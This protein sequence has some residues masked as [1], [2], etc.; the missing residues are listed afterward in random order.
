MDYLT[1]TAALNRVRNSSPLILL[2][3]LFLDD[4]MSA[5]IPLVL[6]WFWIHALCH[7]NGYF[8]AT[9][10]IF[11]RVFL[12]LLVEEISSLWLSQ[13]KTQHTIHFLF[14]TQRALQLFFILTMQSVCERISGSCNMVRRMFRFRHNSTFAA[15]VNWVSVQA[16]CTNIFSRIA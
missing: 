15:N 13:Y 14:L 1:W 3:F 9:T 6:S 10:E 5:F 16:L 12:R 7:C 4:I 8:V 11:S 2:V